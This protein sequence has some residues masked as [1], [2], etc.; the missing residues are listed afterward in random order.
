MNQPP[1]YPPYQGQP[2][3]QQ[4]PYGSQPYGHQQ[5]MMP[6]AYYTP[7][8]QTSGKAIASLVIGLGSLFM[9]PVGI[10]GNIVGLVLGISA[11]KD[12]REPDGTH[13]G[14]GLAVGGIISNIAVWLI[15]VAFVGLFVW[16]FVYAFDQAET[17]MQRAQESFAESDLELI[18]DRLKVYHIENSGSLGPGGPV[19]A[20]G[21]WDGGLV[22]DDHPRVTGTLTVSDLVHSWEL[23][24]MPSQ[25]RIEVKGKGAVI[26]HDRSQLK[27][28]ITSFQPDEWQFERPDGSAR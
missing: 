13:K 10:I 4:Q 15:S 5:Q 24:N 27:L 22:P 2:Q 1:P 12:T 7:S 16:I 26:H 8:K 14:H 11:L 25:Y 18:H 20:Y 3:G 23:S 21:D 9:I 17:S 28:V 6:P 19:L